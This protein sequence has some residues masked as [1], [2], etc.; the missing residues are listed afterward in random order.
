MAA[1]IV[2]LSEA[3]S[4]LEEIVEYIEARSASYAPVVASKILNE[5]ERLSQFPN[6]GGLIRE[7][8]AKRHRHLVCY[9]YRII[10]RVEGSYVFIVT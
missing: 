7:D 10:Y 9:N 8:S 5:V 1:K 3:V 4:D 6:I 2:W